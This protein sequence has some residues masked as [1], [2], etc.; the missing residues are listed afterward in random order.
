MSRTAVNGWRMDVCLMSARR[1]PGGSPGD[2][3]PS[4]AMAGAATNVMKAK[5]PGEAACTRRRTHPRGLVQSLC[6]QTFAAAMVG[7]GFRAIAFEA[8]GS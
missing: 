1:I 3:A 8:L 6:K 7:V 2:L 5:L 4:V